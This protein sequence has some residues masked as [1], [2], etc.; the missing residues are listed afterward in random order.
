MPRDAVRDT[1]LMGYHIPKETTVVL[2]SQGHHF[3]SSS[4]STGSKRREYPGAARASKDLE[5]FDP[6]RWLVRNDETGEVVFDGSSY[7]QM[8]FGLGIRACWGCKLAQLEMKMMLALVV[9]KFE[10]LP[11]LP[12]AL[13]SH[14]AGFDISY[15][16]KKG[17]VRLRTRGEV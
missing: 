10:L 14:K 7:P 12:A 3:E 13:S 16:A 17:F 9:W 5:V 1:E 15:R 6:E 11:V 8:A 2:V 4:A